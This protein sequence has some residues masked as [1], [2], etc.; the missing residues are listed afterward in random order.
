MAV[1]PWTDN[2]ST[3][4]AWDDWWVHRV[5]VRPHAHFT[6]DANYLAHALSFAGR[7][8]EAAEVF[9]AIGPFASDTPWSYCG[10]AVA[11]FTRHRTWARRAAVT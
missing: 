10:D 7:Y 9:D 5:P 8:R 11:L 6:E 2:P 3:S 4:Q 1:H